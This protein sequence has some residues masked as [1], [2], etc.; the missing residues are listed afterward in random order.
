MFTFQIGIVF[1]VILFL[2]IFLY[3][4]NL[5]ASV[6]FLIAIAVLL[7]T[8]VISPK[9]ALHGFANKQLAVIILLLIIGDVFRKAGVLEL[10]LKFLFKDNDSSKWFKLKMM[11][12]VGISSAFMNNTPIVAMML[13]YVH[14]WS[15]SKG[16][17]PSKFL[18]PLS[19]A[20]I[21][22][23]CVTLIGTSTNL[24]VNGLAVESGEASLGIFDFMYVGGVMLV[25]GIVY[26][27]IFGNKLLPATSDPKEQFMGKS[28]DFFIETH[29][30]KDSSLVGKTVEDGGLRN[31]GR[32]YLVEILRNDRYIYPVSPEM[33]LLEGDVLFF[34]GSTEAVAELTKKIK[35][36]SLPKECNIPLKDK[37]DIV[38]AVISHNSK[39]VGT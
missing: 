10:V 4:G 17:S 1:A 28:R 39:L 21:L 25:I 19:Y 7:V 26:L 32:A 9:E 31:L 12:G 37:N 23:G 13:S 36:L 5:R 24:I 35:G 18:I 30:E 15:R 22:G 2:I 29:I 20:S 27:M 33:R 11:S 16:F 6:T 14:S 3:I 38:E 34:A 8:Q